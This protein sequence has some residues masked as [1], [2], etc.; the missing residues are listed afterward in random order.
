MIITYLIKRREVVE[1]VVGNFFGK[2]FIEIGLLLYLY[3][4]FNVLKGL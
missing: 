4:G 1:E 2:L 3:K